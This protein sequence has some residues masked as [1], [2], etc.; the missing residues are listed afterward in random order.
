MIRE[1]PEAA[2][3][4]A[5]VNQEEDKVETL[6]EFMKKFEFREK[7]KL[8]VGIERECHLVG[9]NGKI[10]PIAPIVLEK[11]SDRKKFGYELSACQLEDRI[12]PTNISSIKNELRNNDKIIEKTLMQLGYGRSR[13]EVGPDDMPLDVYPDPAGRYQRITKSMPKNIL[14]A[15]C[16]VIG[17]HVHIGMPDHDS[18]IAVYNGTIEHFDE[19][20]ATGDG[21][22]GKRLEL[23]KIMAPNYMPTPYKSWDHFC[24][25][26]VKKDFFSDPRKC[27]TLIRISIH[28]TIEFRM[29]GTTNN[30]DRIK[31]WTE[32]CHGLCQRVL[33]SIP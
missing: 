15:A 28:G 10:A 17:T 22:L 20:C 2:K 16:R 5:F 27:W 23:Y 1:N 9:P 24:K 18:A 14:L 21:S 8:L 11:L 32:K 7:G 26:A 3:K 25:T 31:Q 19:L 29:F 13:L 30:L 33:S 12:G 4:A 6:E